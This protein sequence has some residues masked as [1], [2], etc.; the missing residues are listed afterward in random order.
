M[1][2]YDQLRDVKGYD[3]IFVLINK[4]HW[5]YILSTRSCLMIGGLF[6]LVKFNSSDLNCSLLRLHA[7]ENSISCF[8]PFHCLGFVYLLKI[9]FSSPATGR[10]YSRHSECS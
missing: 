8:A 10:L 5:C 3:D 4:V 7:R 2:K 6:L 9:L 1:C